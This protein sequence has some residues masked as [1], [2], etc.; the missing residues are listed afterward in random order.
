MMYYFIYLCGAIIGLYLIFRL[1]SNPV[2]YKK[3]AKYNNFRLVI[4]IFALILGGITAVIYYLGA[5]KGLPKKEVL[6]IIY[7]LNSY[8]INQ[9]NFFPASVYNQ[10]KT[11]N[12]TITINDKLLLNQISSKIVKL[13]SVNQCSSAYTKWSLNMRVELKD[14]TIN[15]ITIKINK[16]EN[17]NYYMRIMKETWFGSFNLGLFKNN[18]LGYVIEN[19]LNEH[20]DSRSQKN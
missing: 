14:Q 15:N 1:I 20:Y 10:I 8:S 19:I 17:G 9:V 4:L 2:K 3:W 12:D 5:N 13:Q 18:E 7:N 16:M 6:S 11:I